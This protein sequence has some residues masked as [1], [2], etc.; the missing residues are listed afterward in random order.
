MMKRRNFL[1]TVGA[2]APATLAATGGSVKAKTPPHRG[3]AQRKE[4]RIFLFDDGRHAAD[5]YAF[6]P[7]VTPDNHAA[8]VDQ[9]ASSGAD[10]FVYFA[11]VEGGTALYPS[12]VCQ[13]WGTETKKWTHY[14]WYRAGKILRQLID[15]GHDPLKIMC[16]RC[17]E[18]GLFMIASSWVSLQGGTREEDEG[19]G[20][21]SA[22]AMDNPQ[23]HVG[24]DPDPRAKGIR[25]SRFNFLHAE[26][27]QERL[28]LFEELLS[29][30]E[31]DGVDLNL[32][33]SMPFCRFDQVS[34]LAP[35]LTQW[36]RDLR[37]VADKAEQSQ[38]RHKRIFTL[39]PAHPKAWDLAGYQVPTWVSEKLVD[40]LFC[41]SS[42]DEDEGPDQDVDLSAAVKLTRGTDCRV[43]S[44]FHNALGRQF[45]RYAT[46]PMIWA[47]ALNSWNQ[48]VDG[49]GIG[50]HLWAPNGWPWTAQEYETLRLLGHPKLLETSDKYYLVR[51]TR[52]QNTSLDWLPGRD[53]SL[54]KEISVGKPVKVSFPVADRLHHW[55]KLGRV[56]SVALRVRF[57]SL[58][59][60]YDQIK[61]TFNHAALPDSILQ[62]VDMTYR[63]VGPRPYGY[64]FDFHLGPEHFPKQGRNTVEVELLKRDPDVAFNLSVIEVDCKI[65]YRLHRHFEDHP[66]QY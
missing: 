2:G 42:Y 59:P 62:K 25:K 58:I 57:D 10:T 36:L 14:V 1:K 38:G 18:T 49:F 47:G 41:E 3:P 29:K 22:F 30:Y 53:Q 15:E 34:E 24:K 16:D 51:S 9:L 11:T 23:F 4:P 6:E 8:I 37:K 44:V 45:A 5:L 26:V 55:H 39:I 27:R 56:K 31:T 61:V 17:H 60:D 35:V 52:R 66:I 21:V 63:V 20:R 7:P 28:R 13:L 33:W 48:G 50:D 64:A 40:G 12:Q 54:P 43:Y 32:T 19:L 65:E 46:P